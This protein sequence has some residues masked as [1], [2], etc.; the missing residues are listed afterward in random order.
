MTKET[1]QQAAECKS[2][3]S[4]EDFIRGAK[5]QQE[6]D[7][8]KFSKEDLKEAFRSNYTPFS[9]TNTGDFDEDFDKWFEQ[10]KKK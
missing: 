8:N 4:E 1:L 3:H 10:F 2:H 6:Q 7:K 9:A 5:W